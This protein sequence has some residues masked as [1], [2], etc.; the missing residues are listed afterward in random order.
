MYCPKCGNQNE[1]NVKFC[2]KCGA[3]LTEEKKEVKNKEGL[4]KASLVIGIISL[5]LSFTCIILI[6]IIIS[7][8]LSILGLVL[9]IVNVAK[10][11]KKFAGIILNV[12]AIINSFILGFIVAPIILSLGIFAGVASEASK[13]G[14]DTNKFLNQLYN[15]LDRSTSDNYVAGNYNCKSFDGSGEKGDYIVRFELNENNTFMWGKYNDTS[16]NYVRGTYTFE[17]LKKKNGSGEYS[18]YNIKLTGSEYYNDGVKQDEPYGSEY[19][20]GITAVDTKKQGILMNV[21]T[22]NMYYCYEEK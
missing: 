6:P 16:R 19:E 7:L 13:E 8:P 14:S 17:D 2:S 5:I 9:G 3:S 11:G 22:Y 12:L 15:E 18:Y 21:K 20:F 4:G 10:K 1:E